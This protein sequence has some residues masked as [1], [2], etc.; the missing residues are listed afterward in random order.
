M[1]AKRP[2]K[3]VNTSEWMNTYSDTI[4]LVLCFFVLLFSFSTVNENK[5]KEIVESFNLDEFKPSSASITES[6]SFTDVSDLSVSRI[7]PKDELYNTIDDYIENHNLSSKVELLSGDSTITLRFKDTILFD[8]DIA[9]LRADGKEILNNICGLLNNSI[10]LIDM[11]EIEGHT[12]ANRQ[13][14]PQFIDTFEFSARRAVNVLEYAKSIGNIDPIKLCAVG[15]GQYHPIG[16]NE[17]EEGRAS[18]RRVEFVI[19][20]CEA[21]MAAS[22]PTSISAEDTATESTDP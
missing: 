11:I 12:A 5:W 3:D 20:S 19:T 13:G 2:K 22:N 17:T 8:P 16:N 21:A 14:Q 10:D 6:T 7:S 4:T 18:N 1:R 15:Y 9:V